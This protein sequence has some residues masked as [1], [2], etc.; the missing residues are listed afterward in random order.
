MLH[1]RAGA[2]PQIWRDFGARLFVFVTLR[3]RIIVAR[4][5][6]MGFKVR[7]K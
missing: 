2:G 5:L 3:R 7:N 4:I 1:G 6:V